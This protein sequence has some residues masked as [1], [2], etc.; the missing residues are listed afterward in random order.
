METSNWVEVVLFVSHPD[1]AIKM[2]LRLIVLETTSFE[3]M[4][5]LDT[6]RRYKID[7]EGSMNRV[8]VWGG[9]S[10]PTYFVTKSEQEWQEENQRV[11]SSTLHSIV[12]AETEE[13]AR[14]LPWQ[15][16]GRDQLDGTTVESVFGYSPR[17][18]NL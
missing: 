3:L 13:L 17:G 10:R 9:H 5:G 12:V 1:G 18:R 8:S 2:P 14:G 7:I 6:Q 15:R 16:N 11:T 4:V